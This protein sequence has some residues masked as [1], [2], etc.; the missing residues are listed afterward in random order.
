MVFK[1]VLSE[2][3]FDSS[4]KTHLHNWKVKLKEGDHAWAKDAHIVHQ[5][6]NLVEIF[7]GDADHGDWDGSIWGS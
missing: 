6:P 5:D 7:P 1:L 4:A 3:H 2:K